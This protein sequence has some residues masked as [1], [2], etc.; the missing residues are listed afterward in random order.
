M[1]SSCTPRWW[2]N[3]SMTKPQFNN[4]KR[5]RKMKKKKKKMTRKKTRSFH[6]TIHFR[7]NAIDAIEFFWN[8]FNSWLDRFEFRLLW[9]LC[10]MKRCGMESVIDDNDEIRKSNDSMWGLTKHCNSAGIYLFFWEKTIKKRK[11]MLEYEWFGV[12]ICFVFWKKKKLLYFIFIKIF[13]F[14]R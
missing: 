12:V 7:C 1:L 6:N 11:G 2:M 8:F 4:W 14:I 9:L 5:N 13:I 3:Q 10:S